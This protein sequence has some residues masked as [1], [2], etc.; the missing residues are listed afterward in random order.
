MHQHINL[1]DIL[2]PDRPFR[3][4]VQ[5]Y[6]DTEDGKIKGKEVSRVPTEASRVSL[7]TADKEKIDEEQQIA[8]GCGNPSLQ[9]MAYL[10]DD[11]QQ[12]KLWLKDRGWKGVKATSGHL[13]IYRHRDGTELARVL[14]LDKG[15]KR[16]RA[17]VDMTAERGKE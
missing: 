16:L 1:V 14:E 13:T 3:V 2:D 17:F 8:I 11:S 4:T 15:G 5:I 6:K 10:D 7:E 9:H 12:I